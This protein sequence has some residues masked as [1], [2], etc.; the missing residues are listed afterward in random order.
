MKFVAI[1]LETTGLNKDN[2]AIIEVALLKYD[3][4]K[5]TDEFCSLV[6]PGFS[7][8][9]EVSYIT[10]ITDDDVENSPTFISLRE[11]IREFIGDSI[12][13]GHNVSF[14]IGFLKTYG[15]D[16]TYNYSIDTFELSQIL[17]YEEKSLSLTSLC[18]SLGAGFEDAHR[19]RNDVVA[20]AKL[21][22]MLVGI[23]CNLDESR[24]KILYFIYSLYKEKGSFSIILEEYL[25]ENLNFIETEIIEDMII[26]RIGKYKKQE[27]IVD[28]DIR[29]NA[30]DTLSDNIKNQ[31]NIE[32]RIEQKKMIE[33]IDGSF[34]DKKLSL[35]EAPT[36]IGKTFAYLIPAIIHSVKTGTQV[37]IST[38]TKGLQDQIIYKD[39]PKLKLILSEHPET[40][41]FTYSKVKG[42]NNYLSILKFFEFIHNHEKGNEEIIFIGKILF[43]LMK[44]ETG[45]LDEMN[46]FGKEFV[47]LKEVNS[48]D[49]R[50]LSS[51]NPF[52]NNEFLFKARNNGKNSN[53]VV[54]NHS[55]LFQDLENV[56]SMILPK[57]KNLII[58]EAHNLE[59][60]VTDSLKKHCSI[61]QFETNLFILEAILKQKSKSAES[62][63]IEKFYEMKEGIIMHVGI[64]FDFLESYV[65]GKKDQS[66]D[67][68]SRDFLIGSDLYKN[69]S[70]GNILNILNSLEGKI[71]F[72]L[73]YLYTVGDETFEKIEGYL[74]ELEELLSVL[75]N[76]LKSESDSKFIKVVYKDNKNGIGIYHTLLNVGSYLSENLWS[77]L[78]SAVLTSATLKI[79]TSFDFI[80]N[81]LG[82]KDFNTFVLESDFDYSKQALIYIPSDIGDIRKNNE[83]KRINEFIKDVICIVGGRT[84]GLFTSFSTIKEAFLQIFPELKKLGINLLVQGL[85]GG[86]YKLLENFK[87]S[88]SNSVLFGTDSFWEGVDIPGSD[89]E[90]LIIYK[91]P[92]MVPSDPIFQ[93]RSTLYNDSFYEYSLPNMILKFKQG[94]GR[95]IRTKTDKGIIIILDKRIDTS[96]G[97]I[98]KESFPEGIKIKSG[99]TS[100]FLNLLKSKYL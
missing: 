5:L 44:T 38:N 34:K 74:K 8:P 21:L 18:K 13:V 100:L 22:E 69:E 31:E 78:D 50:V 36:G 51:T 15:V 14:D 46:F 32:E 42:R 56:S 9:E 72:L 19:A 43:W 60:S 17:L 2:D 95:L 73:D 16:L 99:K 93:A 33:I 30:L 1:D 65:E 68:D 10:G 35:I 40:V 84:L 58:D 87:S 59:A 83:R 7:I 67:F 24:K 26:N 27:L 3:D 48:G 71:H 57:I 89:L 25:G 4:F 81:T 37:V 11:K 91:F 39:I 45:E 96:W 76:I 92:F 80:I 63:K 12:V 86:K 20:T 98:V 55:L 79:S 70:F 54:V 53:I 88:S 77:K 6:N 61:A 47:L 75:K 52:K 97:N 62:I 66:R 90:V 85:G 41:D 94:L 82:L 64:I 28:A 49:K 23:L 29:L